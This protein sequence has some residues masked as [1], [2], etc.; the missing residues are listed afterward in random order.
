MPWLL[1]TFVSSLAAFAATNID[2][3][4]ILMLFFSQGNGQF[5]HR[6]IVA[7]QYLGF[8]AVILASLPGFLAG[9]F[10][11]KPLIGLLGLLPIAVGLLKLLNPDDDSE[12]L[13]M[14]QSNGRAQGIAAFFNPQTYQVAAVTFA[15]GG[16]NIGIYV[17]LFA[18][19]NW[20]S[21][22]V[23]L[24]VFFALVGIWCALARYLAM[25]RAI[26]PLLSRY[27]HRIVP[28]VLMG[29]GLYI[30]IESHSWQLFE[31]ALRV[32]SRG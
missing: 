24:T 29:L 16:D 1:S 11:S 2:D 30:L 5:R 17:P 31:I 10:I 20:L 8:A 23:T 32:T 25:H 7:G 27:S 18:S 9:V 28:F 4:L 14:A 3:L 22:G 21:L 19:S 15:N 13:Q 6:H 12:T 26:A